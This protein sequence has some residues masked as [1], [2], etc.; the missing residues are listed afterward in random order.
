VNPE[1]Y[2]VIAHHHVRPGTGNV[3]AA[4]LYE[5]GKATRA[6]PGCTGFV[7][8]RSIADPDSFAMYETYRSEADWHIHQQSWHYRTYIIETIKPL[9]EAR[10]VDFFR[11]LRKP[12]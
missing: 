1:P 5:H 4:A 7:A 10:D 11:P 8:H 12:G 9:L 6:E 3:V 2:I